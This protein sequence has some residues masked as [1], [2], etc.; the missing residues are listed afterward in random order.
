MCLMAYGLGMHAPGICSPKVDFYEVG[1][2][3]I[4]AHAEAWHTYD[5]EFRSTQKGENRVNLSEHSRSCF[6]IGSTFSSDFIALLL[7]ALLV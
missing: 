2:N 7:V 6:K 4:K 5:S 1:H 3:L